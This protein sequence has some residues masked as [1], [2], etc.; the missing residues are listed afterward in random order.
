ME[1][2]LFKGKTSGRYYMYLPHK[3]AYLCTEGHS[4][5]YYAALVKKY[6]CFR[7]KG[8]A[9]KAWEKYV[10]IKG[11]KMEEMELVEVLNG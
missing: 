11:I 8:S 4:H 1:A 6:C 5:F 10:G 9:I 2:K 3:N 7:T